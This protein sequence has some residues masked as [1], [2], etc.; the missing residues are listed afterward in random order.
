MKVTEETVNTL[1]ELVDIATCSGSRPEYQ[2]L[3]QD[4]LLDL[5]EHPEKLERIPDQ[6]QVRYYLMKIVKTSLNS[7]TSPFYYR[8]RKFLSRSTPLNEEAYQ[9]QA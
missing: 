4:I 3:Q 5:L 2:D 7:S 8:Y 1:K 6:E 9:V